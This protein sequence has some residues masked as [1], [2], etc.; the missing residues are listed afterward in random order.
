MQETKKLNLGDLDIETGH[1]YCGGKEGY[2]E[3][4]K[5]LFEGALEVKAQVQEYYQSQNWK[6]YII[7]VH[8]IKSSMLSIGAINL[9]EMAKRL[10]FAGKGEDYQYISEHHEEMLMEYDRVYE[11]M[12]GNPL[13]NTAKEEAVEEYQDMPVIDEKQM[14]QNVAMFEEA[15]YEFDESKMLEVLAYLQDYQWKGKS[16]SNELV[17]VK[18]KVEMMDYMSALDSLQNVF[19]S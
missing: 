15:V 16:L 5:V 10:E 3:V 13:I 4:L 18:R 17:S 6:Q 14:E 19:N 7:S 11:I 1:L 12:A 8:G 2:L 9:S